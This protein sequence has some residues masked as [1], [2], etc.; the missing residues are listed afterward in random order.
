[1]PR[2]KY[3][4]IYS[5]LKARIESG[6]YP[7]GGLLPSE[8]ILIEEFSCS[9]NTVRRALANLVRDGY[10]QTRQGWGVCNIYQPIEVSAYTMGTIESFA[11]TARRTG[12][13]STTHV[14]HFSAFTADEILSRRTGFPVG[15][16]LFYLQRIHDL[17]GIPRIFNHNYS[18]R[19]CMPG[20]TVEIAQ[21]S[22][23][24]YLEQ[25]VHMSIVTSKR[26][27]TVE[28]ADALDQQWLTLDDFNCLA[29]VSS[30]TYNS[31]GIMF[32]YT[33]SRHHPSIFRFQDNAVR[34]A[35]HTPSLPVNAQRTRNTSL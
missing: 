30:Q 10:V 23:Y 22:I 24:R 7:V 33:Q 14:V 9:R 1:M 35:P 19:D 28:R 11:E 16:E 3:E 6:T 12:Q 25:E 4:Q 32:E 17:D 26:T 13:N 5:I 20:L 2:Q 34:T 8:T 27:F 31:E 18:R 15:T 29:V 21:G